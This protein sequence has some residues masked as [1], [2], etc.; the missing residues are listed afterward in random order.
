M[1]NTDRT[2]SR[3]YATAR[4]EA[5]AREAAKRAA[6][7]AGGPNFADAGAARR[8]A[9]RAAFIGGRTRAL[10]MCDCDLSSQDRCTC[11]PVLPR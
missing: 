7:S 1:P 4:A 2:P 6:R 10:P 11:M 8:A 5:A 3:R 9:A